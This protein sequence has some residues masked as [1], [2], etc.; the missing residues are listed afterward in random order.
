M[1]E[2]DLEL[3]LLLLGSALIC[4][5]VGVPTAILIV[6]MKGVHSAVVG[7]LAIGAISLLLA[8]SLT[9]YTGGEDGLTLRHDVSL[10][11]RPVSIGVSIET[12]NLVLIPAA[13]YLLGYLVLRRTPFGTM[14][15]AVG[16]KRNP[17]LATW[18]QRRIETHRGLRRVDRDQ[19]FWRC[20][21][22]RPDRSRIAK[23]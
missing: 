11:G 3:I 19:R 7:T 6:R 9:T 12:Y 17:Q 23:S 13:L 21:V 20:G 1:P 10:F 18:L 5:A 2:C 8:N 15:R 14:M 16:E 4:S 22:L